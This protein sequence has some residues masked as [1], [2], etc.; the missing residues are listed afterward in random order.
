VCESGILA[1]FPITA[2]NVLRTPICFFGGGYLRFF[3]M[4]LI[5]RM[6]KAVTAKG[7][8]V[9]YY[10]RPRE[11]D[12]SHPRLPM[13]IDKRF[14]C[15]VNLSTTEKKIA[16]ITREFPFVTF[17]EFL[18]RYRDLLS[19]RYDSHKKTGMFSPVRNQFRLDLRQSQQVSERVSREDTSEESV[20]AV[21]E[22]S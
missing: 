7:L 2:A 4:W 5:R 9:I 14:R 15:Y 12:P 11:I 13:P 3:P 6:A 8:P 16:R 21:S 1:E 22:K 18:D 10:V 17:A 20:A 19:Y